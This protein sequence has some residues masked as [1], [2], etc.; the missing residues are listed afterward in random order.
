LYIAAEIQNGHF[1]IAGG[2]AGLKVSW[3]VT[4]TRQDAYAQAHPLQVEQ[5]KSA[6]EGQ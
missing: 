3:Q 1:T 4:G 6:G 2:P 5:Q